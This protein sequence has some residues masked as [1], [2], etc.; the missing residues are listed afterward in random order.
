VCDEARVEDG[1][2]GLAVVV[3]AVGL[4]PDAHAVGGRPLAH[5]FSVA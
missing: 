1:V 5:S 4:A 2:D 3:P